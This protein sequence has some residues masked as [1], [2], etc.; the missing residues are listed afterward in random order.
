MEA[1]K[2]DGDI[3]S[4]YLLGEHSA[5]GNLSLNAKVGSIQEF[6]NFA[7]RYASEMDLRMAY[8]DFKE[9]MR[10]N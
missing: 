9:A 4:T 2:G 10:G 7:L 5:M 6:A 3:D 8:K 1:M